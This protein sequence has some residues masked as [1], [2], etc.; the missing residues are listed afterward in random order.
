[1]RYVVVLGF[2]ALA[3]VAPPRQAAP[4]RVPLDDHPPRK[5]IDVPCP[6]G[7]STT[8]SGPWEDPISMDGAK[9]EPSQQPTSKAPADCTGTS[10]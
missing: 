9:L 10:L 5:G 7:V 2:G 8:P 6:K 4:P 1:V 3:C